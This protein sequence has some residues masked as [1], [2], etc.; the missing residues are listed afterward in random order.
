MLFAT[1]SRDEIHAGEEPLADIDGRVLVRCDG[2]FF[3][4]FLRSDEL[5]GDF[6]CFEHP[7]QPPEALAEVK[8]GRYPLPRHGAYVLQAAHRLFAAQIGEDAAV[9]VSVIPER[10]DFLPVQN[11]K[12]A[13]L[14]GVYMPM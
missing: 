6:V 9:G 8:H 4:P 7:L 3:L 14:A 13:V 1:A 11:G 10:L 12:S 2:K 5:I